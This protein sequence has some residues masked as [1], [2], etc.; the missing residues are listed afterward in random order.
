MGT[1][2]LHPLC[3]GRHLRETAA[4][5]TIKMRPL[6]QTE[7]LVTRISNL[8]STTSAPSVLAYGKIPSHPIRRTL[9]KIDIPNKDLLY[10]LVN[11]RTDILQ[12]TKIMLGDLHPNL[13]TN[14]LPHNHIRLQGTL[15]S[16]LRN[17]PSPMPQKICSPLHSR[18]RSLPSQRTL[19]HLQSHP[20]HRKMHYSP[21]FPRLSPN[22]S[23]QVML[24]ISLH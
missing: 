16:N 21:L 6:H 2:E 18:P 14:N 9:I 4:Y 15:L 22:R 3:P 19:L 11:I 17:N 13:A 12:H 10:Q 1:R 5:N 23:I 20:I 8:G 7:L 24:P